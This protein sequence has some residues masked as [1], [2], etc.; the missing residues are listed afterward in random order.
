SDNQQND[1]QPSDNKLSDNQPSN[2]QPSDNQ[3][4]DDQLSNDQLSDDQLNDDQLSTA[5]T[6]IA[7]SSCSYIEDVDISNDKVD[8]NEVNIN[9]DEKDINEVFNEGSEESEV[10][11]EKISLEDPIYKLFHSRDITKSNSEFLLCGGY[12]KKALPKSVLS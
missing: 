6:M 5:A 2:N 4:C 9:D 3:L 7:R 8:T 10:K 1:D 11:L 12:G